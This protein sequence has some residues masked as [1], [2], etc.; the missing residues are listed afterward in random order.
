[1]IN[2]SNLGKLALL[3]LLISVP[4]LG[5]FSIVGFLVSKSGFLD[6]E[7][8]YQGTKLSLIHLLQISALLTSLLIFLFFYCFSDRLLLKWYRARKIEDKYISRFAAEL[9]EKAGIPV[10][11]VF[12]AKSNMPNAFALGRSPKTG[13][14]VLTESLIN[15][16]ND[17]ELKAIVAHEIAHIKNRDTSIAAYAA[18]LAGLLISFSTLAFWASMLSGSGLDDDPAPNLIKLFVLSLVAPIAAIL[19]YT[20][21]SPSREHKADQESIRINNNPQ[22]FINALEKLNKSLRSEHY[23]VNLA[24]AHLFTVN[25]LHRNSVNILDYT[26]P[27]YESL[28]N[29][30]PSTT[31][32]LERLKKNRQS[33]EK[34]T[35]MKILARPLFY[36][37][38]SNLLVLFA[39]VIADAFIR[40]DFD[41]ERFAMISAAY[42][43]VLALFFFLFLVA[44]LIRRKLY[45]TVPSYPIQY[46]HQE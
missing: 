27:T 39:I 40:K 10:P 8:I 38:M 36:S 29:T 9:A 43:G 2:L 24:H 1:M 25:P 35:E 46:K 12:M 44:F 16:L 41:I 42:L 15:L 19:I 33:G 17:D 11:E 22:S 37:F 28:F 45:L 18:A 32:R 20:F 26:V 30:N 3:W 34:R 21:V 31:N 5:L 14:I 4:I 13:K 6:I 7:V 23:G